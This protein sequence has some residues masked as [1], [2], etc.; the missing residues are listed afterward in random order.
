MWE[1]AV[2]TYLKIS[3]HLPTGHKESYGKTLS[4]QQVSRPRI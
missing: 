2:I 1:N 4:G 3:Q